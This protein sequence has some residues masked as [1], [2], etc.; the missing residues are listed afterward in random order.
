MDGN[1]LRLSL[2]LRLGGYSGILLAIIIPTLVL[3]QI[4]QLFTQ[5]TSFIQELYLILQLI[6]L[7]LALIYTYAF[8]NLAIKI[9]NRLL[10]VASILMLLMSIFIIVFNLFDLEFSNNILLNIING[11]ILFSW[12]IGLWKLKKD[13][14]IAKITGIIAIIEGF[15]YISFI[16]IF[17]VLFL[18]IP[19]IILE[20]VLLFQASKRFK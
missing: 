11:I 20:T 8:I 3:I 10:L 17:L 19:S 6:Y 1:N 4:Y 14:K 18:K 16:F 12:G 9:R 13:F 2:I 7:L 5:N 15:S